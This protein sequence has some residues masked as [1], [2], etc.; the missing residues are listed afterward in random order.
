MTPDDVGYSKNTGPD[1]AEP[2]AR[3]NVILEM[4]MLLASLGRKRMVI[5]IK[6]H[7]EKP[8]DIA[9]LIWLN[10]NDHIKEIVPRLA[11]ELTSAGFEIHTETL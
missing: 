8:S 4:G 10:Y 6:G 1:G 7:L 11:K 2:R 9:G 3:Q 5:I